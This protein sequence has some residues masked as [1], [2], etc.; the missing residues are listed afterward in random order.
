MTAKIKLQFKNYCQINTTV[1]KIVNEE[2][3]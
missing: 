3:Q 1:L 2:C